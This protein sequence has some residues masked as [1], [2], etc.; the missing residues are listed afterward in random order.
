VRHLET[1]NKPRTFEEPTVPEPTVNLADLAPDDVPQQLRSEFYFDFDAHPFEHRDLFD[2][3]KSV[4]DAIDGIGAYLRE[5]LP[6]AMATAEPVE[7]RTQE[8]YPGHC[9]GRFTVL[10]EE[11]SEF[12][13]SFVVGSTEEDAS[14]A[15]IV[16]KRD[17][18]VLGANVWLDGGGVIIGED[19][20]VEPG[21]GIKGP[22]VV[23]RENRLRQGCYFR[24]DV[25]IGNAGT[26]RGEIK[27]SVLMDACDFPHPSYLGDS[28]C[29]YRSHFGNQATSANLRVFDVLDHRPVSIDVDGRRVGLRRKL[30]IVLGDFSQVGCNSVSDPGVFVAP[31]VIVYQLTRLKKGFYGPDKVIKNK[32]LEHDV[33][34]RALLRKDVGEAAAKREPRPVAEWIERFRSRDPAVEDRLRD[35]Y[36]DDAAEIDR[37]RPMWIRTLEGFGDA[38]SPDARILIARACGRVNLL[39]MHI[40]HRGGAVN[41]LGVGDT[42][43]LVEPRDDDRVVIRNADPKYEPRSFRI[44]DE[45]PTGEK[46]ADW[47]AWTMD[48]YNERVE[49]GSQADWSNYVRAGVLYL[50]HLH[51]RA[52]GRFDPPLRGMNIFCSGN[53][54]PASGLSSSSSIVVATMEAC[55]R[56]NNLK[57][58]PTQMAEAGQLAEWYVGTRGGGGDHAAITFSKKGCLAHIG[59]FPVTVD[60]MPFPDDYVAVLCNSLVVAAK[61]AG[62]RNLFNQRVAGY[63]LGLLL[64]QKRFPDLAPKMPHLRD[65]SPETLGVDEGAIY[66]ML[67]ALPEVADREELAAAL[68]D[69]PRHLERIFR[70]HKPIPGGYRVRQVCLYGIA[71]CRRSEKAVELL[72]DGD[73]AGFGE[74]ISLSH[75][76]DRITHLVDRER[77]P[78]EKPL[79]DAELDRLAA[80][81]RSGDG[82]ARLFR[83]PG[84]YDASC[85]ELDAM[86]DTVKPIAGVVGA[87]LVG[88]GLGGCIVVLAHKDAAD[89]VIAAIEKHYCRPRSL[90]IVAQV[91]PG[92]GGSQIIDLG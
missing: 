42:L 49:H 65:V 72:H 68:A 5:I 60:M 30:G 54:R 71:E 66:E 56:V 9:I 46:I 29:G 90:P 50:Q 16:V 24:G 34:E 91:C 88:A 59:S 2:R 86:V 81:V 3:H 37:H 28:A 17:A 61:T 38:F 43:F 69:Q 32:P 89:D 83:Q 25:L 92:V 33:I 82:S 57:L 13:P 35:I 1:Q 18:R 31:W 77:V 47:D 44:S 12:V 40:D 87:G 75:D 10:L 55:I 45:L 63:E 73:V 21:G 48:R 84:G 78:L 53:V 20:I 41:A 70:S 76:G 26:F 58:T 27:N 4:V 8:D 80:A 52:N 15:V 14:G 36:G 7:T 79:P 85:E 62:A 23:G 51:T 6:Q 74:L 64:L 22:V 39:G 11:G 67:K 19:T